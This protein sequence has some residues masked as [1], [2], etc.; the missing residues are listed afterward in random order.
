MNKTETEQDARLLE[1]AAEVGT[2]LDARN[3][4]T[5]EVMAVGEQLMYAAFGQ[6]VSGTPLKELDRLAMRMAQRLLTRL[7]ARARENQ[8]IVGN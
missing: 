6:V 7:M 2:M 8:G 5:A 1:L 3:A 4:T